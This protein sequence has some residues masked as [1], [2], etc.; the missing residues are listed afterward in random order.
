MS[1][2]CSIFLKCHVLFI[3]LK[4]QMTWFAQITKNTDLIPSQHNSN[5]QPPTLKSDLCILTQNSFEIFSSS[6]IF[7]FLIIG[8]W[9]YLLNDSLS[10][11]R[12]LSEILSM[13][14]NARWLKNPHLKFQTSIFSPVVNPFLIC[15]EQYC[16]SVLEAIL[17]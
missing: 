1:K 15:C 14:Q 2:P 10:L 8:C 13:K 7:L 4:L 6:K 16:R 17:I 3:S 5:L 11:G 12:D 9:K